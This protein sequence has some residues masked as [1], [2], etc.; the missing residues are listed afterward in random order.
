MCA[1]HVVVPQL[2][3]ELPH[4]KDIYTPREAATSALAKVDISNV[5]ALEFM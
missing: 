2:L 3:S 5:D 4:I 1:G